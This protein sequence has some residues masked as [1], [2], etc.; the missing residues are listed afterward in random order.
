MKFVLAFNGSRG[1]IQPAIA[2][3]TELAHRGHSPVLAVPPNLV[4][5]AASSGL[6]THS[7]GLDT[8]ELLASDLV[9]RDLKSSNPITRLG[10]VAE[11]TARGGTLMQTQLMDLTA[12]ADAIV[13]GS[14]GQERTLNVAEARTLPYVPIHYCPVR[15][16]SSVFFFQQLT[17]RFPSGLPTRLSWL[18]LEQ[19]LWRTGRR[20][21]NKMRGELGL[22]EMDSPAATAIARRAVP[23]IQAY[24]PAL[25][26]DLVRE[27]GER[28]P[29]TGF[30]GLAPS[31]RQSMGVDDT[32]DDVTA[33]ID[34]GPP[35]LY[36]GFGSMTL[37]SPNLLRD[38]IFRTARQLGLRVL[39]TAGWTDVD[40]ELDDDIRVVS[41][42]DHDTVLPRCVAAVHHGGAG[43]TAAS[44]RAGIPTLVCWIGADQPMWGAHVRR[45]GAGTSV[46][47][48]GLT[49]DTFRAALTSVLTPSTTDAAHR[50]AAAMITPGE[51]VR[52][53]ADIVETAARR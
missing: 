30:L 45:S 2:L 18:A 7:Y 41:A 42:V 48:A 1:D 33:W 52:S 3:G 51:A 27:W 34:A 35:P 26:P 21:E 43:S 11:I 19:L 47:A 5:F 6:D 22:P 31:T 28:R 44:L 23:E 46:A 10:A 8:K 40:I 49:S 20:A 12:D 38:T 17:Q 4:E 39:V 9:G 13:G 24:D 14:A 37:P 53:A 25:F 16:N 15:T 32:D 36:V 50:M 29:L